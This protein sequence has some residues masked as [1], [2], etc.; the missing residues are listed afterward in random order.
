[1]LAFQKMAT[2]D[3]LLMADDVGTCS[4]CRSPQRAWTELKE[5]EQ[6]RELACVQT[7]HGTTPVEGHQ[8]CMG[9]YKNVPCP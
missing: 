9:R 5:K 7:V 6:I 8:W 3:T 1:M 4:Y 2:C